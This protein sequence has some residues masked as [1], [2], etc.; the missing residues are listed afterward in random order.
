MGRLSRV[1]LGGMAF[2]FIP[3]RRDAMES[4]AARGA[5]LPNGSGGVMEQERIVEE[6]DALLSPSRGMRFVV[7]YAW[8]LV[9]VMVGGSLGLLRVAF[10][11]GDWIIALPVPLMFVLSFAFCNE[12][13]GIQMRYPSSRRAAI[14]L[15]WLCGA[16][17]FVF[18]AMRVAL[19]VRDFDAEAPWRS[20]ALALLGLLS[21][22]AASCNV[23]CAIYLEEADG[24]NRYF[25]RDARPKARGQRNLHRGSPFGRRGFGPFYR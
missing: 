11:S 23:F 7:A 22:G 1:A 14:T 16:F 5:T 15:F 24:A 21:V 17:S 25:G 18:A 2:F 6:F 10:V 8:G 12:A 4:R 3:L 20:A 9:V 13:R 19:S